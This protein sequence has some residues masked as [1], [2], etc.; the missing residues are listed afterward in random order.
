MS[1]T[2]RHAR[3]AMVSR[4]G[5]WTTRRA[6]PAC[7]PPQRRLCRCGLNS[8]RA[9]PPP[10]SCGCCDFACNPRCVCR[11]AC[12]CFFLAQ[13]RLAPSPHG[14]AAPAALPALTASA[15]TRV[16][17]RAAAA[18]ARLT[19]TVVPAATLSPPASRSIPTDQHRC[20]CTARRRARVRAIASRLRSARASASPARPKATAA[21]G[22]RRSR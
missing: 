13:V 20:A 11:S 14:H 21:R 18:R 12:H 4:D 6:S 2:Q 22:S 1:R 15:W 5:R 9:R 19:L 7:V 17:T 10:H 8:I 16:L 3:R